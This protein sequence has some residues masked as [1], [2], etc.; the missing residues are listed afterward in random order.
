MKGYYKI[1][2]KYEFDELNVKVTFGY[3]G[4]SFLEKYVR[5]PNITNDF[6]YIQLLADDNTR[7]IVKQKINIEI[8][9]LYIKITFNV[10]IEIFLKYVRNGFVYVKRC[11]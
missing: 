8:N 10:P 2:V 1:P 3:S 5:N 11:D 4:I 7:P 6:I 9:K